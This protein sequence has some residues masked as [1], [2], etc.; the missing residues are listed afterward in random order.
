MVLEL[1]FV[2]NALLAMHGMQAKTDTSTPVLHPIKCPRC[3]QSNV[4]ESGFCSKCGL[5]LQLKVAMEAEQKR[6]EADR[7]MSLLLDD[8][9]VRQLIVS[10]L[11][12]M[13]LTN[14]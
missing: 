3:S 13:N 7:L 4:A 8:N 2:D 5:P 12:G 11:R 9:E 10:K 14:I 1:E 6:T